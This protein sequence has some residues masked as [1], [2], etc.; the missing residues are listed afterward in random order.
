MALVRATFAA[1]CAILASACLPGVECDEGTIEVDGRCKFDGAFNDTRCGPGTHLEGGVCVPDLPP[2][3]CE[4]G[5]TEE[6]VNKDGV[7]V[8]EG[9]GTDTCAAEIKCPSPRAGRVS[10]CGRLWDIET[11]LP[12]QNGDAETPAQPIVCASVDQGGPCT[13]EVRVY[14]ALA[15]ASNPDTPQLPNDGVV[16]DECGRF[17]IDNVMLPFSGAIGV[18]VDDV[19]GDDYATTGIAFFADSGERRTQTRAYSTTH[20]TAQIWTDTASPPFA[21][22][23]FAEKGVIVA[24]FRDPDGVPVEGVKITASGGTR[25]A[26]DYYFADEDEQLTTVDTRDATGP[27]GAALLVSSSLGEHSGTGGELFG[28]TWQ[29]ALAIAIPGVVFA[30]DKVLVDASDKPC[31]AE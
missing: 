7:I 16:I 11:Q 15:F 10:I 13:R 5:T 12:I 30:Q 27:N 2:T 23:T 28:C 17:K 4:E 9:T 25:P 18:A 8:C 6:V 19:Q 3:I 21:P 26:D 31:V 24:I 1:A 29:S 20:A 22:A 14:D